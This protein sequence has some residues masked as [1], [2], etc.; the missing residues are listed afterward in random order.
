LPEN[1]AR[2]GFFENADFETVVSCFDFDLQDYTRWAYLTGWRK[3]E[4]ASL[5][6]NQFEL[7]ARIMHLPGRFSKNGES[8]KVPLQGELW[9]II[10][11]RWNARIIEY[12]GKSIE[13]PLVFFRRHGREVSGPW[14]QIREFRKSWNAASKKAVSGRLFHDL[15]RTAARN[16]RRA[17]V[18]EEVA[19]EIIG[20]KSTSMFRRYNITDER[21]ICEAIA[22]TQSYVESLSKKHNIVPFKRTVAGR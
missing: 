16:M 14:A 11:R 9:D 5:T 3:G 21:D 13:V 6:W 20:H 8:R 7:D 18:S 22:K 2:Q 1:N 12:E 15:R 19:M 4:I 17:G 10:L